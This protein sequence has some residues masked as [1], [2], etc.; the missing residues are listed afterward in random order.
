[1]SALLHLDL[2]NT[3]LQMQSEMHIFFVKTNKE[4]IVNER[5]TRTHMEW[6]AKRCL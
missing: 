1:M 2:D 4:D 6:W 5:I 3:V